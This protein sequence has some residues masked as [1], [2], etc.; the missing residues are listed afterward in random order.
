MGSTDFSGDSTETEFFSRTLVPTE[1]K[2][3]VIGCL[4]PLYLSYTLLPLQVV[5]LNWGIGS[6]ERASQTQPMDVEAI[7]REA[8]GPHSVERCVGTG[9]GGWCVLCR[10]ES[11]NGYDGAVRTRGGDRA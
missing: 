11:V 2:K 1:L 4:N 3:H 7:G 6:R 9:Q 10:V 8:V 5:K